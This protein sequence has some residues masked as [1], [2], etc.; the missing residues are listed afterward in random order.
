MLAQAEAERR[1]CYGADDGQRRALTRKKESGLLT[2]PYRN[3]YARA[4]YVSTLDPIE[5]NRHLIR[6]LARKHPNWDF[7]GP[8]AAVMLG[9]EHGWL[10]HHDES[11]FIAT[12]NST[13]AESDRH[14]H[15]IYIPYVHRWKVGNVS[16]T[17]PSRTLV[18]CALLFPFSQ[19]LALFDSAAR[20]RLLVTAEIERICSA[21]HTDTLAV[22][23]LLR[24]D[25]GA[26]ENGGESFCRAL[27]IEAGF[28]IPELQH[29]FVDPADGSRYRTDFLWHTTDGRTV[30][31]EYDGLQKYV[32][33][34]MTHGHGGWR[35]VNEERRHESA[36]KRAGVTDIIRISSREVNT[37]GLLSARLTRAGVPKL[38]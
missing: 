21:L 23:K 2:S 16:V 19:T 30:V 29:E 13:V 12:K 1:Y 28:A 5:R 35:V 22:P 18:D 32:D 8:S 14:L 25:D 4:E 33:P 36:L 3:V 37:P 6:T 17:D 7:A 10:M 9:L 34:G 24:Y 20:Q 26:S 31:L 11:V 15:R 27:I 38:R